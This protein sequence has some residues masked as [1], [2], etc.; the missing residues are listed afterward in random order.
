MTATRELY[1]SGLKFVGYIVMAQ[2]GGLL[3]CDDEVG[4]WIMWFKCETNEGKVPELVSASAVYRIVIYHSRALFI[5]RL[6][7]L[8][9]PW[10]GPTSEAADAC[11]AVNS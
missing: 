5:L 6:K 4:M 11:P 1:I 10:A 2:F 3:D 7:Y 9:D 8:L